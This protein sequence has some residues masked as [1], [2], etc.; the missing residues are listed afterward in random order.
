M[1][2]PV[3][4]YGADTLIIPFSLVRS[5]ASRRVSPSPVPSSSNGLTD[6]NPRRSYGPVRGRF[7][8]YQ[9]PGRAVSIA[10][11][12]AATNVSSD[13]RLNQPL[14]RYGLDV[15][16]GR[17]PYDTAAIDFDPRDIGLTTAA[18]EVNAA[19][20]QVTREIVQAADGEFDQISRQ[21]AGTKLHDRLAKAVD[22]LKIPGVQ[23][24]ETNAPNGDVVR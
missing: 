23:V 24:E 6:D 7:G 17:S 12:L 14:G 15:E 2:D 8:P 19:I 3:R 5:G 22:A 21:I 4:P 10:S 20:E 18:N 11:D 16:F 1:S 9:E 13:S